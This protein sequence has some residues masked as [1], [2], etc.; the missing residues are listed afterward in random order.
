MRPIRFWPVLAG[1]LVGFL[2]A[3]AHA[4][5]APGTVLLQWT[6]P[7]DDSISGTASRYDIRF[8]LFP[9]TEQNFS[10]C[11]GPSSLP[12]PSAPGTVQQCTVLG[13]LPGMRYYFAHKTADERLNWSKLSNVAAYAEPVVGV[14]DSGLKLD[15]ASPFPNPTRSD[16]NFSFAF[17][18]SGRLEVHVFDLQGRLVRTLARGDVPAGN[19][20]LS[21]NLIDEAGSPVGAGVY[22]VKAKLGQAEF[23]RKLLVVR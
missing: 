18:T 22:L 5:S 17:P 7:G 3:E 2:G 10:F 21:W 4:Q 13:L 19:G 16:V 9:I 15:F 23:N 12:R 14:G 6:A 1:M 11:S 20:T 8:S